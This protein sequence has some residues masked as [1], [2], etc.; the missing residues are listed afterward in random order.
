PRTPNGKIDRKPLRS[1]PIEWGGAEPKVE[2]TAASPL[3]DTVAHIFATA[4]GVP[5]VGLDD[6]F[7]QLGGHSLLAVRV[8]NQLCNNLGCAF[9]LGTLCEH[10]T[11]RQ[12]AAQVREGGKVRTSPILLSASETEPALY[13]LVGVQLYRS[14][15]RQLAGHYSVYGVYVTRESLMV[16]EGA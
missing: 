14:L 10:P 3:E 12:V 16:E 8:T 9:P 2:A 5:R 7:F 11:V 15:A 4:L 6:D 13:L 1:H